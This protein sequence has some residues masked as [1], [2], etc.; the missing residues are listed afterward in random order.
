MDT[1]RFSFLDGP[2]EFNSAQ[3]SIYSS[4]CFFICPSFDLSFYPSILLLSHDLD[5]YLFVIICMNLI[6]ETLRSRHISQYLLTLLLLFLRWILYLTW[7]YEIVTVKSTQNKVIKNQNQ[8]ELEW[9]LLALNVVS[10][11]C[12]VLY[13]AK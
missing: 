8:N 3:F 7:N 5:H 6:Q 9:N 12:Y 10:R 1:G 2:Y 11:F 4:V 13:I